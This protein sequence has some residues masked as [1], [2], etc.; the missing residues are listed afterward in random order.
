MLFCL[1]GAFGVGNGAVFQLVGRRYP[2]EVGPVTGLV[3]AAGGV[4]GFLLSFGF[5]CAARATGHVRD[6]LRGCSQWSRYWRRWPPAAGNAA[7]D[8]TGDAMEVAV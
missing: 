3:G 6:R 8:P 1:V 4:G 2:T 7:G 5:G